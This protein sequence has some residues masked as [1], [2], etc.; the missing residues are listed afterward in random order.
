MF[1]KYLLA[2][3]LCNVTNQS[4]AQD[5]WQDLKTLCVFAGIGGTIALTY[6]AYAHWLVKRVKAQFA[7]E[8]YILNQ[9][10]T[11]SV[12]TQSWTMY[13]A[14]QLLQNLKTAIIHLHNL[15]KDRWDIGVMYDI[16]FDQPSMY[17]SSRYANFPL[18]QH[19]ED[20][21]RYVTHLKLIRFLHMYPEIAEINML[22]E[23]LEYIKHLVLSDYA[24]VQESTTLA[25]LQQQTGQQAN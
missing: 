25:F 10:A 7:H 20:I 21:N 24:Y 16:Y 14:A 2:I 12:Q 11:Y 8:Q 18:L 23:Q 4:Y 13:D 9:Y 5:N 6:K 22:I 3:A 15:N 19:I 1:K 17:V